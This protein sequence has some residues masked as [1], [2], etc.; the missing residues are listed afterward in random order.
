MFNAYNIGLWAYEATNYSGKVV[1]LACSTALPLH[2]QQG[3][4]IVAVCSVE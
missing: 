3:N 2:L 4:P 1:N